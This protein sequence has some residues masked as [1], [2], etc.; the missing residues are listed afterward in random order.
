MASWEGCFGAWEGI[1]ATCGCWGALINLGVSD[2]SEAGL[3]VEASFLL[4]LGGTAPKF[5]AVAALPRNDVA[6]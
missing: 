4:G 1:V 2:G 5:A 6:R 3:G